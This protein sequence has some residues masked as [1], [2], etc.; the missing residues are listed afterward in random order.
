MLIKGI[1]K[2]FYGRNIV[3]IS[4]I[5]LF[6][7]DTFFFFFGCGMCGDI[8]YRSFASIDGPKLERSQSLWIGNRPRENC[9]HWYQHGLV[10][11][12]AWYNHT[13]LCWQSKHW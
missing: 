7:A 8:L 11:E 3:E 6:I 10:F 5:K 2:C 1:I 9:A 13:R 4:L 12:V